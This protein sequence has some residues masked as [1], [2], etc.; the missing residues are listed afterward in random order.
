MG[1]A[2]EGDDLVCKGIDNQAIV[3][4]LRMLIK[5]PFAAVSFSPK[6]AARRLAKLLA[7]YYDEVY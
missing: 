4:L 5:R 7:W 2:G 1:E 3:P 6:P